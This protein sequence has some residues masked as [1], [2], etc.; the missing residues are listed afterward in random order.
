MNL[1]K[2]GSK[3]YYKDITWTQTYG[4]IYMD[5]NGHILD[6][7]NQDYNGSMTLLWNTLNI[8]ETKA[9]INNIKKLVDLMLN[10]DRELHRSLNLL[11]KDEFVKEEDI[12]KINEILTKLNA[13][14]LFEY[15]YEFIKN[16]ELNDNNF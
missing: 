11:S 14:D 15:I 6:K 9:N 13:P 5:K 12:A 10:A 4:Y 1:L 7:N 2:N 16:L 3:L 8:E